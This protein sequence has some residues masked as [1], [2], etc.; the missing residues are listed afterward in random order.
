MGLCGQA[1][2]GT[3]NMAVKY[4]GAQAILRKLQPLAPSDHRA[5][6][7]VKLITRRTCTAKPIVPP[8]ITILK[9]EVY[10]KTHIWSKRRELYRDGKDTVDIKSETCICMC[11]LIYMIT[12]EKRQ[13]RPAKVLFG[14][15]GPSTDF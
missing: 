5:A 13:T 11:V 7:C 14:L 10:Q 9:L 8:I 2:D 4:T 3:A 1:C 15:S 12:E 6:H